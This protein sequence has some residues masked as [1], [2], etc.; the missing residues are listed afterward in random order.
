MSTLLIENPVLDD[1]GTKGP[2]IA[3]IITKDDQMRGY[4]YGEEI[5]AVC[6]EKFIPTRDPDRYP[7]CD[8][9]KEAVRQMIYSD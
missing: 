2:E 8:A 6:G 7:L 3:H 4:V 1:T 5:T 9:C